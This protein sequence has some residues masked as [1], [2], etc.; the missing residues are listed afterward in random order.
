MTIGDIDVVELN[1]AFAAQVIPIMDRVRHPARE[2]E[3][4]RRRDRARPPVRDDRRADHD[5][6]AER[7]GDRRPRGRP[8]DDVRRRRPGRG[9]GRRAPELSRDAGGVG[10]AGR[11]SP[12]VRGQ[13]NVTTLMPRSETLTAEAPTLQ[14]LTTTVLAAVTLTPPNTTVCSEWPSIP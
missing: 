4:A 1:E 12:A 5:H 10:T 14:A 3:H 13:P 2:A 6:A 11:P 9:D 7:D 8:G